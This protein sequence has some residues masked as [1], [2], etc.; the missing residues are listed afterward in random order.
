MI[1]LFLFHKRH[2]ELGFMDKYYKLI[3]IIEH[4]KLLFDARS[5]YH[6]FIIFLIFGLSGST[7]LYVSD[8]LLKLLPINASG[9]NPILYWLL[10]IPTVVL[11]Y[12]FIL[13]A[14]SAIFGEFKY[15]SRYS[16]KFFILLK[17]FFFK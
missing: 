4:S 8:Y 6:L 16:L 2:L 17:N 10:K 3:G 15:F 11:T 5:T 7:S 13:L 12:Q 1:N 9:I 14:V